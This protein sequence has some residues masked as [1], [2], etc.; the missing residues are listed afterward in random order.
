MWHGRSI[1]IS[2]HD[3][4]YEC[5]LQCS[6]LVGYQHPSYLL[7]CSDLDGYQISPYLLQCL[8]LD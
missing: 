4:V 5:F 2:V 8:D 7:Q 1:Y 3:A 6:D